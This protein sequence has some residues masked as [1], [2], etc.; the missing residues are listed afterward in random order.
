MIKQSNNKHK[1]FTQSLVTT[2]LGP[3]IAI[4]DD[5]ALYGLR[6]ADKKN[7]ERDIK[8]FLKNT[9][10]TLVVGTTSPI[11][12]IQAELDAYFSG[13]LTTFKTPYVLLGSSFQKVVWGKLT[14]IP[15][16]QTRSYAA[17]AHSIC[18]P[19]AYRAVGNA[20]GANN[21]AI[22]IPCHRIISNDGALGG[23]ASGLE[24]K[25]WLLNHEK[26]ITKRS[27]K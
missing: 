26:S 1:I 22:I 14:T 7:A 18:K 2:P 6:F 19:T 11:Q 24:R 16:G 9:K 12:S 15:F 3:M 27:Q 23:Y 4:S 13:T 8:K 25:Q 5:H 21:L 17:H 20:N 10:D